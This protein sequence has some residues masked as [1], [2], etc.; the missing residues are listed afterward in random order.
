M[1]T[2]Q[3]ET[4]A[5]TPVRYAIDA[6]HTTVGFSVR[7][8]MITNVHGEFEKVEGE[9]LYDPSNPENTKITASIDVASIHTREA[10]R[11]EHLRSADF[12][13]AENH[14]KMTFA[15]K[16]VRKTKGGFE[17]TGDLTI[18][19]TTREVVLEVT[20][21]TDE[22]TDPWGGRRIGASAKAK[23]KRSDFGMQW[24]AALEAGGV[25]VGDEVKI[26]IDVSLVRQ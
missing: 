26:S 22:H 15:S 17:V 20:D 8:M 11:D 1:S 3:S 23:I 7:H 18:R 9:V 14:P 19:G 21:V 10:K 24:N 6:S 2:T 4:T 13:D 5:S 25:L 16:S 12:F